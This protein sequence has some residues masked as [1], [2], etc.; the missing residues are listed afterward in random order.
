MRAGLHRT[1]YYPRGERFRN[2]SWCERQARIGNAT[3]AL[4][5]DDVDRNR[6]HAAESCRGMVITLQRVLF[7]SRSAKLRSGVL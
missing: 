3:P 1:K 2:S 6:Q 5:S 4:K 7:D